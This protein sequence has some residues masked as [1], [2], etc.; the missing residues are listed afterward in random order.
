M[1]FNDN[2]DGTNYKYLYREIEEKGDWPKSVIK[3]A[4]LLPQYSR[5]YICDNN[6][7]CDIN[8]FDL[9]NDDIILLNALLDYRNNPI[10]SSFSDIDYDSLNTPLS[11]LIYLYLDLKINDS[12]LKYELDNI[13]IPESYLLGLLYK[14]YVLDK[15]FEIVSAR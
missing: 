7:S 6:S 9:E 1:L 13:I 14:K 4:M 12:L 2:Y 15:I 11:C 10:I 8:F 5:Y 3:R